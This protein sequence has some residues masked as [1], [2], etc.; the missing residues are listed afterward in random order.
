MS[1]PKRVL[2]LGSGPQ[3]FLAIVRSLGRRGL[4]VHVASPDLKTPALASRYI[5]Q[6]HDL[7]RYSSGAETW[8]EAL[9]RLLATHDYRLVIPSSDETLMTLNHHASALGEDRIAIPNRDALQSFTDKPSTRALAERVG[10]PICAGK[11]VSREGDPD[12]LVREFGLPLALKP[13]STYVLGGAARNAVRIIRDVSA[14][15][16]ALSGGAAEGFLVE[17]FFH[18]VGVGV[19]VL[20]NRGEIVQ[21]YQ[22][23]RLRESSDA[24][25]GTLRVSEPVN[26]RL[27]ASVAPLAR[28][29]GLHGVAMFEF[30]YDPA[31]GAHVLLEVNPRF[32]GSLPLAVAAGADFPGML[33]DLLVTG[34]ARPMRY[35]GGVQLADMEGEYFRAVR[36]VDAADSL[37]A[38]LAAVSSM[39]LI[40]ARPYLRRDYDSWAEDDEC[41]FLQE[42]RDLL[43]HMRSAI[44]RRLGRGRIPAPAQEEREAIEL[45]R[46]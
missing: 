44:G 27:L 46:P 3:A 16:E 42:R 14:L 40:A 26:G 41:P 33:Y 8:V 12:E 1:I 32:W 29:T 39:I 19:S 21:A 4:E 20:A 45:P 34:T 22:H 30:R 15:R 25:L 38:R 9:R 13:P 5:A 28:A 17:S 18:G 10:T 35:R 36:K 43:G 11:I 37:Q 2:V 6:A 24:G 23:R 31:R 7:P